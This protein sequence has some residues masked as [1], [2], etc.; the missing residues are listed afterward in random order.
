[1]RRLLEMSAPVLLPVAILL[2]PTP[3]LN[4]QNVQG[5]PVDNQCNYRDGRGWVTCG[6][7]PR[8]VPP[9]PPKPKAENKNVTDPLEA[10]K[11]RKEELLAKEAEAKRKQE[12]FERDKAEALKSLK[13]VSDSSDTLKGVSSE[14]SELKGI[15]PS[16]TALKEASSTPDVDL[17]KPVDP[18][19]LVTPSLYLS[20]KGQLKRLQSLEQALLAKQDQLERW[21]G[22]LTTYNREFEQLRAEAAFGELAEIL[23]TIPAT[24]TVGALSQ[25][26]QYAK[27]VTPLMAKTFSTSYAS[28][29]L[30]VM[31]TDLVSAPNSPQQIG[32]ALSATMN[33]QKQLTDLGLDRLPINDPARVSIGRMQKAL[34]ITAKTL[35]FVAA[36]AKGTNKSKSFRDTIEPWANLAADI[37]GI[38][39]PPVGVGVGAARVGLRE[40]QKVEIQEATGTLQAALADNWN[41]K[42]YLD[43]K[44]QRLRSDIVEVRRTVDSCEAVYCDK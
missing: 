31:S 32:K 17:N 22:D 39:A 10:E 20:A 27:Y 18:R 5:H 35:A 4:A 9:P 14:S 3:R 13:G 26:Q 29:K 1:V 25:S 19:T 42:R 15:S 44:I 21:R 43:H 8:P 12:Q 33:V 28:F 6:D 30:V 24:E 37:T 23:E 2:L 38:L 11:K 16:G 36:E 34:D 40:A 7:Y 41:A